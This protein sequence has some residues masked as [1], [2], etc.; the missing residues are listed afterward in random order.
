LGI[1]TP[2]ATPGAVKVEELLNVEELL[3]VPDPFGDGFALG[4]VGVFGKARAGG[5]A[6]RA[7]SSVASA[8]AGIGVASCSASN[9]VKATVVEL[10]PTGM[11][12]LRFAFAR[13]NARATM[14]TK[15]YTQRTSL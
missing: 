12:C 14:V 4:G 5:L 6:G 8:K 3:T 1:A 11:S 10:E 2:L 7:V 9:V 15:N 13:V